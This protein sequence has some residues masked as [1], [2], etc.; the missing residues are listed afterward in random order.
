MP[1]ISE[2]TYESLKTVKCPDCGSRAL[3]TQLQYDH[4]ENEGF[5]D[6]VCAGCG[7][8]DYDYSMT[9]GELACVHYLE[10]PSEFSVRWE[11]VAGR[12]LGTVVQFRHR[13]I[14]L[15]RAIEVWKF[16]KRQGTLFPGHCIT[17]VNERSQERR[18][19]IF[20]RQL[21]TT[22]SCASL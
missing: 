9:R 8:Q 19:K 22:N 16:Q 3:Y 2:E 10:V 4:D 6:Y 7:V 11:I 20:F 5:G 1:G 18:N 14:N 21:D 17:A 13:S 12:V 15:G